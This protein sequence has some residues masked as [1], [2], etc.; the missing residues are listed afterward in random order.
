MKT[1]M[2]K[3]LASVTLAGAVMAGCLTG[4]G[5]SSEKAEDSADNTIHFI[6]PY[7]TEYIAALSEEATAAAEENGYEL[8]VDDAGTDLGKQLDL[9]TMAANSGAEAIIVFLAESDAAESVIDA[10]GDTKVVFCNFSLADESV[11]DA[12]HVFIGCNENETGKYQ[13]QEIAEY[14]ANLGQTDIDA[15]FIQGPQN[16]VHYQKRTAVLQSELENAGLNVN[17]TTLD[18]GDDYE[19]A[20]DAVLNNIKSADYDVIIGSNDAMVL[21]ALAGFSQLDIDVTGI[22]V[23]GIDAIDAAVKAIQD[24]TMTGT[25][26][27]DVTQSDLAVNACINLMNGKAFN[28]GLDYIEDENNEF[29]AYAPWVAVTAD[30]V[31]SFR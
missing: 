3:K 1:T 26:Y 13:G 18:G 8:I 19:A 14:F 27:Q 16:L 31:D 29:I 10:A 7:Q 24:G 4:C 30:N 5:S 25:V 21:G 6:I 17:Y 22:P 2:W 28:E 12:E 20:Q 15:L 9:V 23:F 11:L